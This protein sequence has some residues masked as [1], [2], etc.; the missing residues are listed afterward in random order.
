MKKEHNDIELVEG[1]LQ[2]DALC[3]EMLYR[4]FSVSMFR[5][6]LRYASS[7]S[8]AEDMLQ[9][10]FMRVFTDLSRYRGEGSLEGWI[11]RV[12]VRA[13]LRWLRR[14]RAFDTDDLEPEV[15][16]V[17]EAGPAMA[18]TEE[19]ETKLVNRLMQQLPAGYRTVLNLYAVEGYRHEEIAQLLGISEGTSR[20][21]LSKAR[22]LLKKMLEHRRAM[23][24][25]QTD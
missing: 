24:T 8:E 6:C 9:E 7:R 21:Q 1:A 16:A 12:I 4:R 13:A 5:V 19:D 23:V 14:R 2:G 17:Q 10:G 15:L 20:S 22:V 25:G 18:E 11:R 3:E